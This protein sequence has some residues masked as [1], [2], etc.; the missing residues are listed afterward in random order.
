M[1]KQ[2]SF[3]SRMWPK[4]KLQP[5]LSTPTFGGKNVEIPFFISLFC[6]IA[7]LWKGT[8]PPSHWRGNYLIAKVRHF[9]S[10]NFEKLCFERKPASFFPLHAIVESLHL[11]T[12]SRCC[13][14]RGW[15]KIPHIPA[16]FPWVGM[17]W[18]HSSPG[19]TAPVPE[20]CCKQRR[21]PPACSCPSSG[22]PVDF[23]RPLTRR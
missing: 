5:L 13:S 14:R 6:L 21:D 12:R 8:D 20:A 17:A 11:H 18:W 9:W 10:F 4:Y 2:I 1:K 3:G 16:Y 22:A 19:R 15:D 23:S 7:H